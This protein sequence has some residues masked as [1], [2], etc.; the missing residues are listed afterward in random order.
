MHWCARTSYAAWRKNSETSLSAR[1][2]AFH[3][4]RSALPLRRALENAAIALFAL[5]NSRVTVFTVP[6][7]NVSLER[8]KQ[9]V[10]CGEGVVRL[11]F[12]EVLMVAFS[13]FVVVTHNADAAHHV[14]QA[15]PER[16]S[17]TKDRQRSLP[18]DQLGERVLGRSIP[19]S[20]QCCGPGRDTV[21]IRET[22]STWTLLHEVV[23]LLIVPTDGFVACAD[24]EQRVSL[25]RRRLQVSQR[26]LYDD[27]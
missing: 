19:R 23:H 11:L 8:S 4:D 21:L 26:R 5:R 10:R 22:A 7:R 14:R 2:A 15:V 24:L 20:A 17:R 27:P 1:R 18:K 9:L 16:V 6:P 12:A 3:A 25:A 13:D